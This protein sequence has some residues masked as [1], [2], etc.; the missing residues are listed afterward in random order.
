M[1]SSLTGDAKHC[2]TEHVIVYDII[3][4]EPNTVTQRAELALR[5]PLLVEGRGHSCHHPAS[6]TFWWTKRQG[7]ALHRR[8]PVLGHPQLFL[9]CLELR[10]SLEDNFLVLLDSVV[11]IVEVEV[12]G[13]E[14]GD[15]GYK[16][17]NE[18]RQEHVIR[19]VVVCCNGRVSYRRKPSN[20]QNS[21]FLIKS[22]GSARRA[23]TMLP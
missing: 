5:L 21:P 13:Q 2:R 14:T 17:E 18:S 16:A 6:R 10:F 19:G 15:E 22:R 7:A 4:S 23:T 20:V 1:M 8:L 3:T 9:L 12:A 11:G